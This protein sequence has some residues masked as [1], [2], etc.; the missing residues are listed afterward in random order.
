MGNGSPFTENP[1]AT[2]V[3]AG[4]E[5]EGTPTTQVRAPRNGAPRNRLLPQR[6][7]DTARPAPMVERRLNVKMSDAAYDD[8]QRFAEATGR[9]I[10]EVVR[11]ALALE[12]WWE[13]NRR[14]QKRVLL[15]LPNGQLR[16]VVGL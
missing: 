9:T 14:E 16:E 2:R 7:T 3:A 15:E 13:R 1:G 8:L 11:H 10:S 5:D 4:V 6:A 12:L